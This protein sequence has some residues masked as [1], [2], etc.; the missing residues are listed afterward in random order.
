MRK[1]VPI[2][3][4][5]STPAS[6]ASMKELGAHHQVVIEE[7]SRVLAIR[8]DATNACGEVDD[9]RRAGFLE[10]PLRGEWLDKV[11][12]LMCGGDHH[13]PALLKLADD[14]RAQEPCAPVT[15]TRRP[16]KSVIRQILSNPL[17]A[18]WR[19]PA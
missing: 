18:L 3:T 16:A 6:H 10:Q 2:A 12:F 4:N 19:L 1:T 15:R 17:R 11:E 13:S 5:F 9:Y 8:S 14:I 7:F